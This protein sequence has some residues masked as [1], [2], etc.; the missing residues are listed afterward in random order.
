MENDNDPNTNDRGLGMPPLA[1]LAPETDD[2]PPP[3][4][5]RRKRRTQVAA[6]DSILDQTEEDERIARILD[7]DENAGATVEVGRK[8]P[9]KKWAFCCSFPVTEWSSDSKVQIAHEFGGGSYR[10]VIKRSDKTIASN[11]TF[12]IDASVKPKQQMQTMPNV[13]ELLAQINKPAPQDNGMM[14][15]MM[16]AQNTMMMQFMQ[17]QAKQSADNMQALV[18]IMARPVTPAAA[19]NDKLVE[20]LLHKA[21][22]NKPTTDLPRVIE[23]VAK[24]R[25]VANGGSGSDDDDEEKGDDIFGTVLKSLPGLI[26]IIGKSAS[27]APSLPA[28]NPAP[29]R[30]P[31]PQPK[32]ATPAPQA[33]APAPAPEPA[34]PAE[35][36][37][38]IDKGVLALFLPQVVDLA[39]AD[40]TPE[41]ASQAVIEALPGDQIE[42]LRAL[43]R[44]EDWLNILIDAHRPVMTWT[45][46]FTQLREILLAPVSGPAQEVEVMNP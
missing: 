4:P 16:Q 32:P 3:P 15:Q 41:Q 5:V 26:G 13:Q 2:D 10:A 44:K 33:P 17:M 43:L 36:E 30:A 35:P 27:P 39:K 46:W 34:A 37:V 11:F 1:P 42:V 12:E 20:I 29:R 19:T 9:D 7:D 25:E 28:A 31:A 6:P 45:R 23:A 8:T 38:E 40:Q 24:L 22:D 21:L 14:M 18:A